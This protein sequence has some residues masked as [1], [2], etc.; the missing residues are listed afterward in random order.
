MQHGFA[1][2]AWSPLAK[3]AIPTGEGIRVEVAQ[4]LDRI[5]AE[6]GTDRSTVALAFVLSHPSAPVAIIGTQRSE[7]IRAAVD[8]A[9]LRLERSKV[10]AIVQAAEGVRLP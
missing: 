2:L 10:Y 9:Q 3:G 1:M 7:R 8:A 6:R 5:A 4:T